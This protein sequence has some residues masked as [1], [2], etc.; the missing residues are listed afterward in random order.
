MPRPT[1]CPPKSSGRTDLSNHLV[2]QGRHAAS[3]SAF[4]LLAL[5]PDGIGVR[6]GT[7]A[8]ILQVHG[9]A[10]STAVNAARLLF[11]INTLA[12][13]LAG[14]AWIGRRTDAVQAR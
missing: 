10:I 8:A 14:L 2:E 13:A 7:A 1:R 11:A 5:L 9:V 12:P 3:A 4:A 6:E